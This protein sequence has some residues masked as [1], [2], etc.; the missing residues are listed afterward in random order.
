[1]FYKCKICHEFIRSDCHEIQN[2]DNKG[3]LRFLKSGKPE[4]SR[5][6]FKCYE[7]LRVKNESWKALTKYLEEKYFNVALPP[8]TCIELRGLSGLV[9]CNSMRLCLIELEKNLETYMAN[10]IF[11]NDVQKGK[12]ILA[13]LRNNINGFVDKQLK[14]ENSVLQNEPVQLIDRDK[15]NQ[16][17]PKS[18]EYDILE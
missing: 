5:Y 10:K 6:H 8:L 17:E 2:K 12:Y 4:F 9:D 11:V 15:I 13:A 1:M 16:K 18:C 3:N 14:A 7:D